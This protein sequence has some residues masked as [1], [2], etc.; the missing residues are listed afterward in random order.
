MGK[1]T[2]S[3]GARPAKP[4]PSRGKA[5]K[6][7]PAKVAES[8]SADPARKVSPG[9]VRRRKSR[10]APR[11]SAIPA[12]PSSPERLGET[13]DLRIPSEGPGGRL[14]KVASD[15]LEGVSRSRV[16]RAL[17]LGL[18]RV[19]G[20]VADRRRV[21]APGDAIEVTLPAPDAP[22]V[23][24][25]KVPLRI[26][27]EDAHL[28]VVDK[29]AGLITHPVTGADETSVVHA[30]LH[31]TKGR[32]APAGGTIRPGIVHR[33][34]RETSGAMVVAKTDVAFHGLI[35]QFAGR[36]PDKEY[37][38]LVDKCPRLL[39]GTISAS[40]DRHRAVRVRMAV[41][42][43]GREAVTDWVVESRF[44]PQAS[45][46]RALPRTG[47]THQIRVH[48][49][50]L[51]H[52]ILGDRTYGKFDQPAFAGWPMPRVML[53][54]HRLRI[55]HPATGKPMTFEAPVPPDFRRLEAWLAKAFGRRDYVA[56]A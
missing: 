44:G 42:D 4:K 2:K 24:A 25:R 53:H 20:E 27:F 8:A 9:Q 22:T 10:P 48:L 49:A 29:P 21:V 28:V 33:L 41:R 13:H 35:A 23:E 38:A 52:P 51:G 18:V 43:D 36:E 39:S 50:H 1:P 26:L 12:K 5:P 16:Q 15:L 31:H 54:A 7:R 17:E 11:L 47:R 45:L 14:D 34:D 46:I 40:I 37:L 3:R 55:T 30:L 19:N 6:S 32:L 56:L